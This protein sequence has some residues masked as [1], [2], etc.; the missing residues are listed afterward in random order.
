VRRFFCDNENCERRTFAEQFADFL[1]VKAQRTQRLIGQQRAIACSL[2]GEAGQ[3]LCHVL[4]IPISA[5][6]LIRAIRHYSE[7][8]VWTPQVLGIDDW[9]KRKGQDYGTILV[10][11]ETHQPVDV[12]DSRTVEAVSAWLK[13]HPGVE[14]VSR[15]RGSEYIKG[16]SEGAPQAEQVADRW[17]LLS[18]LREALITLLEKKPVALKAAAQVTPVET[19]SGASPENGDA[20]SNVEEPEPIAI[21]STDTDETVDSTIPIAQQ[22]KAARQ[23]RRQARFEQVHDAYETTRSIRAVA[24]QLKMSRR[25]VKRY[26]NAERCPQYPQG[27][28]RSSKLTPY[29]KSLQDRWQAG[30]TNASQLWRELKQAGFTGSRGLV[31]RWAARERKRLPE[32]IRYRRQQSTDFQ[33]LPLPRPPIVPWS[34]KRASWLIVKKPP[35][36]DE[37]EKQALQRM[38]QADPQVALGVD[39]AWQFMTLVRHRQED[40]LDGWLET[41]KTS[42]IPAL[43]SFANGLQK[44]LAAVR[45][46]LRYA[47]SNGQTEGQVNRLKFIKRSMYG[48]AKF[49]L[50]RKRVLA[51][52]GPT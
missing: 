3:Q 28:V 46:A 2:G 10:D 16:V 4:G 19:E 35:D 40:R 51:R 37:E 52:S 30:C 15:D 8:E 48:R 34:A 25:A 41:A 6:S 45:N 7:P 9:A 29:L 5:D 18:N 39:L 36:L 42:G 21:S 43:I 1:A 13:A 44:D 22:T 12:L 23:E 47:W 26:L 50:L 20:S 49:D 27:R 31:A 11:L 33:A 17:H 14:I 38:L 32:P 24:R